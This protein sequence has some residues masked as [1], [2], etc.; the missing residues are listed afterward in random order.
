MNASLRSHLNEMGFSKQDVDRAESAGCSTVDEAV[1]F[2]FE[3]KATNSKSTLQGIAGTVNVG[4]TQTKKS[5][6]TNQGSQQASIREYISEQTDGPSLLY[7]AGTSS[8]S[9]GKKK[10]GEGNRR[11]SHSGFPMNWL[12]KE[13]NSLD[14]DLNKALAI[15]K[16]ET[17][18]PERQQSNLEDKDTQRAIEESLMTSDPHHAYSASEPFD[19]SRR[20]RS[21]P[22][23][24]VGLRNVANICYVNSLVQVYFT[25]PAIRKAVFSFRHEEFE[26]L[27]KDAETHSLLLE[28]EQGDSASLVQLRNAVDFVIELQNLFGRMALSEEKYL[29]P[30]RLIETLKSDTKYG[31]Q[32]GGQ[33][34]ASEFNQIFL[35]LLE[36]GVSATQVLERKLGEWKGKKDTYSD[37]ERIVSSQEAFEGT[38]HSSVESNVMKSTFTSQLK[39]EIFVDFRALDEDR[40]TIKVAEQSHETNSVIID[41]TTPSGDERNLYRGLDEL[42]CSEIEFHIDSESDLIKKLPCTTNSAEFFRSPYV[43][44][45]IVVDWTQ[46]SSIPAYQRLWFVHVAPVLTIYLQRVR[47]N[48]ET[49]KPEKV[50][51]SFQFPNSLKMSHYLEYQKE[52]AEELRTKSELLRQQ[53]QET[54]KKLNEHR[55]F[56]FSNESNQETLPF[57]DTLKFSNALTRVIQRLRS[58]SEMNENDF[59][60]S[61]QDLESCLCIL[62]KLYE[63]E[64]ALERRLVNQREQLQEEEQNLRAS[65]S[66]ESTYHLHAVLVH[67]GAPDSGHYWTFIKDWCTDQWY[68]YNDVMVHAVTWDQVLLDSIGGN[69]FASAYGIIYIN[70]D[71]VESLRCAS[72]SMS[73]S[74]DD[75]IPIECKWYY[76]IRKEAHELLPPE[77]LEQIKK[78]N[79]SFMNELNT[80]G[81]KRNEQ[82]WKKRAHELIQQAQEAVKTSW[83]QIKDSDY[84]YRYC[85]SLLPNFCLATEQYDLAIFLNLAVSYSGYS[86]TTSLLH[87]IQRLHHNGNSSE[88]ETS[89]SL[90][91]VSQMAKLLSQMKDSDWFQNGNADSHSIRSVV[92][93][94]SDK[95]LCDSFAERL[96]SSMTAYRLAFRVVKVCEEGYRAMLEKQWLYSIELWIYVCRKFFMRE[97]SPSLASKMLDNFVRKREKGI[98]R[99]IQVC[100]MCLSEELAEQLMKHGFSETSE[101]ENKG[102]MMARY[103]TS[104]LDKN[105]PVLHYLIEKWASLA[106]EPNNNNNSNIQTLFGKISKQFYSFREALPAL[107]PPTLS[108]QLWDNMIETERYAENTLEAATFLERLEQLRQETRGNFSFIYRD[109]LLSIGTLREWSQYLL[110]QECIK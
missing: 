20:R 31:F 90:F 101:L 23:A 56:G 22:F 34:D 87:D 58:L 95:G 48:K 16:R 60:F 110:H 35:E 96:D 53:V 32:I 69:K 37:E 59:E 24:P 8:L 79:D 88:S 1:N 102:I 74:T 82:E 66:D 26:K 46:S 77:I 70:D 14:N 39:Q 17:S 109:G 107:L 65:I 47:F 36:M 43:N 62:K 68:M 86:Q 45:G 81:L 61:S 103:A 100:L 18:P 76:E 3:Q 30:Q 11:S 44:K 10:S 54:I 99:N 29:D 6:S 9:N 4:T 85:L 92:A 41:A 73:F 33:Q 64:L 40:K 104:L 93:L 55:W 83:K 5:K 94:F 72:N 7:F 15:S 98:Y 108:S 25:F 50:H 91:T 78:E 28:D 52:I 80:Y 2:L 13:K 67:D 84:S 106:K 42:T 38:I 63:Q 57:M 27:I 97:Q 49:Q 89:N 12:G 51:D 21:S 75:H 105:D 19:P 71:L